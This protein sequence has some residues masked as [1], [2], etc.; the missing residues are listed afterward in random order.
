MSFDSVMKELRDFRDRRNWKKFHNPKNLAMSISIEAG[1]LLE[2]FQWVDER[3]SFEV[4]ERERMRI[5]DEIAD[6]MIYCLYLADISHL[7]PE[8]I[9]MDKMERNRH[10]FPPVTED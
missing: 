10:R 7:D 2:I 6:I 5:A 4:M 3:R 8:K 1:E 9:I